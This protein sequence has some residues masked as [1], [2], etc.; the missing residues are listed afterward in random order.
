VSLPRRS[1]SLFILI[2]LLAASP[3]ASARS[4]QIQPTV[5]G[6]AP[7]FGLADEEH[8]YTRRDAVVEQLGELQQD[9]DKAF[10]DT[11]GGLWVDDDGSTTIAV[12]GDTSEIAKSVNAAKLLG[13]VEYRSVAYS[14]RALHEAHLAIRA[15][16]NASDFTLAGMAL[17]SIAEDIVNN[18]LVVSV[19]D[20]SITDLSYADTLYG[21][22]VRFQS[23]PSP[24]E[25]VTCTITN[26]GNPMKAALRLYLSNGT[27][28]CMSNFTWRTKTTPYL[29]YLGSAGH[30]NAVGNSIYHPS[31]SS[32]GV[33]SLMVFGPSANLDAEL[34]GLSVSGSNRVY[35][36]GNNDYVTSREA[37]AAAVIGEGVCS[38]KRSSYSCGHLRYKSIDTCCALNQFGADG[39]YFVG[40]DSG[41]PVY[42]GHKAQGIVSARDCVSTSIDCYSPIELVETW[43]NSPTMVL[44]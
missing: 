6:D 13:V 12:V 37:A 11:F 40:G 43:K 17:S 19:V 39:Q 7:G 22:I 16:V 10:P 5:V 28:A 41:S 26:C 3:V 2:A 44:S 36:G 9:L 14:A 8:D 15:D 38:S 31:G 35:H 4:S 34:I 1:L 25:P 27:D 23:V 20:P 30:C 21:P 33:V 29:Y 32:V 18:E 42:Y 24:S